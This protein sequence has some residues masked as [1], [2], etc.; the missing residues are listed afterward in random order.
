[1]KAIICDRCK[2]VEYEHSS[3]RAL[4]VFRVDTKKFWRSEKKDICRKCLTDFWMF[5]DGY[6]LV[7]KVEPEMQI[8]QK[9]DTNQ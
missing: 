3:F 1:M 8:K 4:R 6:E 2:A 7:K 9:S 5:V